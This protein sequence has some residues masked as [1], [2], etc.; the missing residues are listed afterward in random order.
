MHVHVMQ[1]AEY[2]R[3]EINVHAQHEHDI[4]TGFSSDNVMHVYDMNEDEYT[5]M[6]SNIRNI[7][8]KGAATLSNDSPARAAGPGAKPYTIS[9]M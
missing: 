6:N 5:R 1:K 4:T 9:S 7:Y 8:I 2:T 3:M